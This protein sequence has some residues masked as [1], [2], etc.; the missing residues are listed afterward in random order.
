MD[1]EAFFLYWPGWYDLAELFKHMDD[2]ESSSN[3]IEDDAALLS[4]PKLFW[5]EMHHRVE[6][7]EG[8][9]MR[10]Q[11]VELRKAELHRALEED[12]EK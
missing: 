9:E 2:P 1:R 8:R 10:Q 12:K 4:H 6:W 3:T 5:D 7:K 11:I